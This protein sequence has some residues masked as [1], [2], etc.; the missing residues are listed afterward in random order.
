ME[1]KIQ[2]LRELYEKD[3]YLWV[4]E[5]LKLLKNREFKLVDWE[6]LLEEIEDMAR[7]ELRSLIS[8]MAVI[9][10][11]LYKWENFRYREDVGHSWISSINNARNELDTIFE[12]YPSIRKKSAEDLPTAWRIAVRRLVR[13]FKEPQNQN[14]AKKYFGKLPTEK[15]FPQKCPYT[16][17]QVMEY[18][19]WLKE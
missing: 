16:F 1:Q 17:E 14:L 5:N 15:D 11:H 3:F 6:N 13:W 12:T 10:E 4:L 7:M 18:E 19:P 8:F 2:S 9:M